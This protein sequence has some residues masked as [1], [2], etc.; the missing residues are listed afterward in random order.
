MDKTT[1][2][3]ALVAAAI[4]PATGMAPLHHE[5]CATLREWSQCAPHD[6]IPEAPDDDRAPLLTT[7]V[8]STANT[9]GGANM[10]FD[11]SAMFLNPIEQP[12]LQPQPQFFGSSLPLMAGWLGTDE[13]VAQS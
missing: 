13:V 4:A 7:V 5:P 6:H 11:N 8:Q 12:M 9:S 3:A 10:P 2:S 1:V